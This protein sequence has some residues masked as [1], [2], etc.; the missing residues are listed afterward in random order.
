M[1][2]A[3]NQA[4]AC[5]PT[6][7]LKRMTLLN[8]ATSNNQDIKHRTGSER[9]F[10]SITLHSSTEPRAVQHLAP[11]SLRRTGSR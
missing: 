11:N 1:E 9:R 10:A 3:A 2:H 8:A 4:Q 7:K 5:F 6:G